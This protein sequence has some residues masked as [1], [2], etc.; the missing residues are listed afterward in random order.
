MEGGLHYA[1]WRRIRREKVEH[2]QRELRRATSAQR[3]LSKRLPRI[4]A[5][6]QMRAQCVIPP[7]LGG[8]S[9]G[10]R[11]QCSVP[12]KTTTTPALINSRENA[13]GR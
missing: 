3:V 11:A 5:A 12:G 2:S 4:L 6:R 1:M 13:G 10:S 7:P 8:F 9:G